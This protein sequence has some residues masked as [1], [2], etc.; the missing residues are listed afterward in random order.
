MWKRTKTKAV[1]ATLFVIAMV[2]MVLPHGTGD[3]IYANVSSSS[4]Q[5]DSPSN[6]LVIRSDNVSPMIFITYSW[7]K[8]LLEIAIQAAVQVVLEIFGLIEFLAEVVVAVIEAVLVK[9]MQVALAISEASAESRR[10]ASEIMACES[11]G[12]IWSGVCMEDISPGSYD[13]GKGYGGYGG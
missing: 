9:G 5:S 10:L 11:R 8:K 7:K 2:F 6:E 3:S 13:P 12:G 4:N 1:P